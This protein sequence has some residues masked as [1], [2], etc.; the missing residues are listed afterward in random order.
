MIDNRPIGIFDSGV[1]GLTVVKAVMNKLPQEN[2]VYFGDTARVPYGPKSIKSI[3]KFSLEI[4]N[5]LLAQNVKA[6]IIACNS[7]SAAAFDLLKNLSPVPVYGVIEAGVD[8]ALR[9]TK[10]KRI[11]IIGTKATIRTQAYQHQLLSKNPDLQI[12][13]QPCPLF[14]PLIEEGWTNSKITTEIIKEYLKPLKEKNIDTLILGCTHYPLL[15]DKIK[16]FFGSSV[17]TI[18][19]A[20]ELVKQISMKN[21]PPT[22]MKI[23]NR[24]NHTFFVSDVPD[25]F[26]NASNNF[27]PLDPCSIR[28]VF[29][30]DIEKGGPII[31]K[32][33]IALTTS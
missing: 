28:K 30:D 29:L 19:P 3:Q 22:D 2:I 4:F 25:D 12:F 10:N 18:N 5:F 32:M 20:T 11:G 31:E 8:A 33:E 23:N 1:G 16:Q 27:L 26:L 14:V 17:R 15:K 7:A 13:T 6:I 24:V 21:I 9:T